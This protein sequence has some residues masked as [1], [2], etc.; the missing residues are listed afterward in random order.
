MVE[1]AG[2]I[3]SCIYYQ[4]AR[5]KSGKNTSKRT[6]TSSQQ[7]KKSVRSH[8]EAS[9]PSSPQSSP[10]AVVS[11]NAKGKGHHPCIESSPPT[12]TSEQEE[13][14]SIWESEPEGGNSEENDSHNE[15]DRHNDG[16]SWYFWPFSFFPFSFLNLPSIVQEPE[17]RRQMRT[18]A[19]GNVCISNSHL[20]T[21]LDPCIEWFGW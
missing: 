12:P 2:F 13:E 19:W 10:P 14:G 5:G 3:V 15:S 11:W 1:L 8:K 16:M 18:S 17:N 7:V 20:S 6:A 21:H 9:P 4:M